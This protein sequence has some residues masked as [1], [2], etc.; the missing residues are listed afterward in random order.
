MQTAINKLSPKDYAQVAN[1]LHKPVQHKFQRRKV[2]VHYI[3]EIWACNL[4]DFSKDKIKYKHTVYNYMLVVVDCFSKF[5]WCF[6][7]KRKTPEELITC[8]E[9]IFNEVGC[10]TYIWF[11]MEKA[12]DSNKFIEFLTKHDVKLYH[13]Y[14][15][16]KVSIAE[17]MIRTLKERCERI[18][19]Q[20]ELEINKY[21]L[22]DS[23]NAKPDL[24]GVLPKV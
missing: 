6:M 23:A 9:Q 18:K 11:D 5:C 12:V 16:T 3:D 15:E 4:M 7:I 17:R 22:I 21:K 1:E 24:V 19:T 10:P 2:I 20:C 13:T 8:Y 14:S